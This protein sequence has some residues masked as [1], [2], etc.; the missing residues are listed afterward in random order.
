[1]TMKGTKFGSST[2]IKGIEVSEEL[3]RSMSQQATQPVI[4]VTGSAV[5]TVE[6]TATKGIQ[7]TS[8]FFEHVGNEIVKG[9]R[10]LLGKKGSS[11]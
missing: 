7:A 5:Q 6:S 2:I 3:F 9:S 4:Y 1:M 11:V 10:R 8:A